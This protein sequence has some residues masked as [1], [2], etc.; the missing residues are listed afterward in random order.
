M[1]CE[2]RV[3]GKT[4][5]TG[6]RKRQEGI[7]G[8]SDLDA[9]LIRP[10]ADGDRQLVSDFFDQMG[11][12]TR[13]FFNRGDGNRKTAMRFFDGNAVD[14]VYFLAEA[15]GR[16]VWYVFL[17][18]I[19]KGVPWLGIAAPTSPTYA[20]RDCMN[21]WDMSSSAHIWTGNISIS[22]VFCSDS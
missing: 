22:S 13:A 20:A 10:F 1:A 12:E 17:W 8:M 7:R 15:C 18:D 16:M 4:N 6:K 2:I 14:T 9:V 11:G 5:L 19:R 21:E 3:D